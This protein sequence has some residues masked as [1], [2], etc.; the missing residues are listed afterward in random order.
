MIRAEA[1]SLVLRR[2]GDVTIRI[3]LDEDA[4]TRVDAVSA[5]RGGGADLGTN[6]RRIGRFFRVLDRRLGVAGG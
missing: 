1:R 2:T 6:A 3:G 4:Q 5:S